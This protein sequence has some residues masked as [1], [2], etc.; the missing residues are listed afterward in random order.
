MFSQ[1]CFYKLII[2]SVFCS[3]NY[4]VY[5]STQQSETFDNEYFQLRVGSDTLLLPG[6]LCENGKYHE[7][8]KCT[9][10]LH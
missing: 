6:V 2:K 7:G 3:D 5:V 9:F 10:A 1:R 8:F 4:P